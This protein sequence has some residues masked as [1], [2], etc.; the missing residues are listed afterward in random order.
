MSCLILLHC[1]RGCKWR[2]WRWIGIRFKDYLI[3]WFSQLFGTRNI[4]RWQGT[5]S[6]DFWLL[7]WLGHVCDVYELVD[8]F[9]S[10]G[11]VVLQPLVSHWATLI[12]PNYFLLHSVFLFLVVVSATFRRIWH[13]RRVLRTPLCQFLWQSDTGFW[14]GCSSWSPRILKFSMLA[15]VLPRVARG[16]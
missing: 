2:V 10:C 12:S 16:R 8:L 14:P 3:S 11:V 13:C 1:K 9:C 7:W 4:K 6:S 5:F 15:H